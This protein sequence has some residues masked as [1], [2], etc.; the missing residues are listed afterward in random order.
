MKHL[1]KSEIRKHHFLEKYVVIAPKRNLRPDTF[2]DCKILAT[3]PKVCP[4]CH[5]DRSDVAH[6]IK[7]NDGDWIIKVIKNKFPAISVNNPRAYGRQEVII[8]TNQHIENSELSIAQLVRI[9]DVYIERTKAFYETPHIKYVAIFKNQGGRAG[10]SISHAHS[11]MFGLSLVPPDIVEELQ[12]TSELNLNGICPD[13]E[14]LKA[15][16]REQRR[17]IYKDDYVVAFCPFASFAPY[18][19]KII[20]I[21]HHP[22]LET[23]NQEEKTSLARS[24]KLA[25]TKL[26]QLGIAYNYFV[27]GTTKTENS[28]MHIKIDPRPNTWGGLELSSGIIINPVAP[29]DAAHTYRLG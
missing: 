10:A 26:D 20:P 21:K 22:T 14:Q 9:L 18:E 19:V 11:Q 28:H 24:I 12:A 15:E 7:N 5:P 23:L 25:T 17:V 6:T 13:C 16:S 27:H 2:R 8:E 3:D 4:F 29:E 1:T